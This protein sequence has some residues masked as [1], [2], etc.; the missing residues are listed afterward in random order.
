MNELIWSIPMLIAGFILLGIGEWLIMD[1]ITARPPRD[2]PTHINVLAAALS[3][4]IIAAGTAL[5]I[6]AGAIFFG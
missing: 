6:F 1:A 5:C 3:V 2:I 4:A